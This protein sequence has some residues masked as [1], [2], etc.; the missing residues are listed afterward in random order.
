MFVYIECYR[1]YEL[2][3]NEFR[4]RLDIWVK[5]SRLGVSF[6]FRVLDPSIYLIN[7]YL[8]G[9]GCDCVGS[10]E[11][12]CYQLSL[13]HMKQPVQLTPR[14]HRTVECCKPRI[15]V[16]EWMSIIIRLS[17]NIYTYRI[18]FFSA[19]SQSFSVHSI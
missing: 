9:G 2:K 3:I 16:T 7:D 4:I 1:C 19:V 12:T 6:H 5:H 13:A 18:F 14:V 10:F 15:K 11:A 8:E 17:Y